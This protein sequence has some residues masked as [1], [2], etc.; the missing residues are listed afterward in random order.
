[1]NQ[2]ALSAKHAAKRIAFVTIG[3]PGK[4]RFW[5]GTPFHMAKSLASVGNEIIHVGPLNA[6]MLPVYQAYSRLCR[7]FDRRGPSPFH[8]GPVAAQYAA[9]ASRK[10]RAAAPDIVFAPAGS[11]FAW[12]IPADIPLVYASD[13]TFRLIENYHPH[14][15]KLSAAARASADRVERDTI[16]RANLLLY[17][18]KWAAESAV[19]DYGADPAKVHVVPWGANLEEAPDRASVLNERR[20]GPCRLLFVGVN[21]EEK[22]ADDAV[23]TLIELRAR[24]IDAELVICGCTPPKPFEQ[25]GLTIVPFLDKNDPAQ[26]ARM[27]QLYHDADFFL[28][29]TR[30]DC[31]PMVFC[32]AA[33]HGVPSI[34]RATGGVPSAIIEGE[35]GIVMPPNATRGDY[36][37][38]IADLF[39]NPDRLARMKRSSRDAYEARLNW[40]A[41]GRRLSELIQTL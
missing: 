20:P 17:P 13:A 32:E 3:D 24:G 6:S 28:L 15:R 7:T 30:A 38:V 22:G 39:A 29:P 18:S 12:G 33:A 19:R 21:W 8:A 36:A 23:G 27:S 10:I 26:R 14:Y 1:M 9:D 2:P 25:D 16:A 31:F 5:S 11:P 41:W 34:A 4:V 37:T 35:T 40:Q